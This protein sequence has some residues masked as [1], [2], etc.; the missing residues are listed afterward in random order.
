MGGKGGL[1]FAAPSPLSWTPNRAKVNSGGSGNAR[2]IYEVLSNS[3][4][5]S[6]IR[7][8]NRFF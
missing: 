2:I 1:A 6:I 3:M 7:S 4:R 5:N 8:M